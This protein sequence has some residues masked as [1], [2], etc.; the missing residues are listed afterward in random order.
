MNMVIIPKFNDVFPNE[1]IP[2]LEDLL[3]NITSTVV[4]STLAWINSELHVNPLNFKIHTKILEALIERSPRRLR[5]EI[6][7]R[8]YNF[9]KKYPER[10]MAIFPLITSLQFI[11]HEILNYRKGSL[12]EISSDDE[13]NIFKAFLLFNQNL[14]EEHVNKILISRDSSK[15]DFPNEFFYRA[16]WPT[17]INQYEHTLPN[18]LLIQA[19][20][21]FDFIKY[22][23]NNNKYALFVENYLSKTKVSTYQDYIKNL[24]GVYINS[25]KSGSGK[26]LARF[27]PEAFNNNAILEDFVLEPYNLTVSDYKADNNHINFKGLRKK[28]IIRF[29]DGYLAVSNWKYVIDKL[30]Q[31]FIFDFF[32]NSGVSKTTTFLVYKSDIGN[33]FAQKK[34]FENLL[35]GVFE[36]SG[37]ICLKEQNELINFDYYY[38]INNHIILFEFKDIILKYSNSYEEIK[39]EIN[40][41]LFKSIHKGKESKEGVLQ[42]VESIHKISNNY[43]DIDNFELDG[44]EKSKVIIYPIIVYTHKSIGMPGINDY[45]AEKFVRSLKKGHGFFMIRELVMIDFEIFIKCYDN[46][47]N[48]EISILNLLDNY[49]SKL[50]LFRTSARYF[51]NLDAIMKKFSTFEEISS[52]T[53][54]SNCDFLKSSRYQILKEHL[55]SNE[56]I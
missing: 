41:K 5:N 52:K 50:A 13:I 23:A 31:A 7:L 22:L 10:Q 33:N 26:L 34:I 29:E 15:L 12:R 48:G 16:Y 51:T 42:L 53:I 56:D 1:E 20:L 55:F 6:I 21:S 49:L 3:A 45:L 25:Y 32:Q 37:G 27:S 24:I 17:F 35:D 9:S 43:H 40:K 11:E 18:N 36:N 46:I 47:K 14:D 2:N 8:I 4:I 44:I 19:Y 38:R 30:Y 39:V 28:P 54:Q